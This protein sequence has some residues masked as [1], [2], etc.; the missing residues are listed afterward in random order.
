[1]TQF[2]LPDL[3]EGLPEAEIQAWHI[4]ENEWIERD[5]PLVAMETAKAVV[6]IPAPFSGRV[7]RLYGQPG[8]R[9]KTGEPLLD[10]EE[11]MDSTS[12]THSASSTAPLVGQLKSHAQI[13]EEAALGVQTDPSFFVPPFTKAPPSLYALAK[14][15]GVSLQ[16]CP[17]T[18]PAGQ[19]T[20]QDLENAAQLKTKKSE[21]VASLATKKKVGQ[22]TVLQG[23]RRAMAQAMQHAHQSIVPVTLVD[24][25][26]IHAWPSKTDVTLRL[27]RAISVAC[28]REPRLNAWLDSPT[29]TL[30]QHSEINL[31][32][33][34]DSPEGLFVPVLKNIQQKTPSQLRQQIEQFKLNIKMRGL[35]P[36]ELKEA[37]FIL[38]NIGMFAGRYATPIILPPMVAILAA[39]RIYEEV[40]LVQ[41]QPRAHRKLPLSLTVDHRVI[42]GG[43]AARFLSALILD[44]Q[45]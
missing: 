11:S 15:L 27:I 17:G 28:Q 5:Q 18:G 19:I 2:F 4:Q 24:D 31:G 14:K 43:E 35:A 7:I 39:G 6:D 13:L 32:I 16:N 41:D 26:D 42:T 12:T 30:Q 1:M 33:A 40:V 36:E 21:A 25:A 22:G 34:M 8:E 23:V 44:L 20:V 29:H 10:I 45:S 37:T 9:I 38:S 3:G